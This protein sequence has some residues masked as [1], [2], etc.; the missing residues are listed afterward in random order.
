MKRIMNRLLERERRIFRWVNRR[1]RRTW[2]D[3]LL[4]TLTHLGGATAAI[5][6]SVLF[7]LLAGPGWSRIGWIA[8]ASLI[9]SH[10]PVAVLKR[11]Y[12]RL[13]PYQIW[14]DTH[15]ATKPL[16]DHSFPSGHTTAIFSVL[17]PFVLAQ[18]MFGTLLL[19]L[20]GLVGLSRIY[21]GLH[22]PSDVLAGAT[23]GS[24]TAACMY[25]WLA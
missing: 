21:L 19:P 6:G 17:V 13:R 11:A 8:V 24:G 4:G 10:L 9:A 3:K 18:P 16:V 7:A 23:V 2:L 5:T 20:A 22:Y 25:A 14:P 15:M 12:R 1:L